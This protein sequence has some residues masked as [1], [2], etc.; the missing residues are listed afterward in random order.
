MKTSQY[1][2]ILSGG[3]LRS[4][5]ESK[6]LIRNI[7][8]Q[9]DFDVLLACLFH[10]DRLVVMRA[11]DV[12]EKI[13]QTNPGYLAAHKKE[14]LSLCFRAVDKELKWHLAQLVVR[15]ALS[16]AEQKKV[17]AL[18]VH[19]AKDKTNSRIVRVNA[20]QGLADL[21]VLSPDLISELSLLLHGLEKENI[22][23]LNARIN[24]IKKRL[25]N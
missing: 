9:R 8:S 15:L 23:S 17:S 14:I 22:P 1:E 6:S 10:R 19:W 16:A 25:T 24:F 2:K 12:I 5:G 3:D 21:A 4:L 18:L 13:T 20:V 7:K 11:A